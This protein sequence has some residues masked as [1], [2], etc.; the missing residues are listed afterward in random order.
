M[1]KPTVG[2][3]IV[4]GI[5]FV[6]SWW[7]MNKS[8]GYDMGTSQFRIARHEVG[9]FGLH[10]SLIR[11]FSW[12]DNTP[13][14]SPFFPG[15]PLVYHYAVDWIAGQL[16]RWGIRI[17]YALNS[18]SAVAMT[19]LLYMLYRLAKLLFGDSSIVGFIA[20]I[21]FLLPGNLSFIDI[22]KQAPKDS[23][24]LHYLWRFPDYI[25]KG[26]FDGS[27]ITIYTTL[28]PYLNQRHLIAG[29]A[30]GVSVLYLVV[31]WLKGHKRIP[32]STYALLGIAIGLATR[33]HLAVAAATGIMVFLL[34][35]GKKKRTIFSFVGMMFL[36]A[37]P[38]L[39]Q[40]FSIRSV[41]NVTV[42]NPGY[43]SPRPLALFSF[44]LFWLYN[45][46]ALIILVPLAWRRAGPMERRLLVGVGLLFLLA[47]C[48][49]FSNRIEH[50]HSL[51]NYATLLM[52]PFVA[53]L[54]SA[55]WQRKKIWWKLASAGSLFFL[56]VSGAFNL[57]VVKNDYQF[58]VDDAPKNTFMQWVKTHTAPRSIFLT[59]PELYDPV[60]L[61][62]RKNYLGHEYYVSVMGYDYGSRKNQIASWLTALDEGQIFSM[63]A[64]GI[65]Y[66]VL[67]KEKEVG[68]LMVGVF[69]NRQVAVY[70]L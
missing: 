27:M 70:K 42:W 61:A 2:D 38:H 36:G 13:A 32:D 6:F 21:L 40:V 18:V 57:M 51:I 60:T 53:N 48:F 65:D 39:I 11:S 50:N 49:Q 58:M 44:F 46:G 67:P 16:V 14:Q 3:V 55:W 12:G 64:A 56:T 7:L 63:R 19:V 69:E 45:L 30:I 17:D 62:G 9:D 8:F 1:K 10:I 34:L 37:L 5:L 20:I 15:K 22:F 68:N 35:I 28:A 41:A 66:L 54:L 26:P 4:I 29:M 23:S 59:Q 52:L 43:L 33:V 25:H 31:G 47:N 24:F